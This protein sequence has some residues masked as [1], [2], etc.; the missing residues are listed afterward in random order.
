[1]SRY[2][3]VP[4][5]IQQLVDDVKSPTTPASVKF[6]KAQVLEVVKEYCEQALKH[7]KNEQRKI[8]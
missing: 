2:N 5:V 1:M 4:V 3:S 6:N 7:Y 8:R